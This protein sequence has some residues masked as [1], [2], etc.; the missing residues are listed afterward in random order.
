MSIPVTQQVQNSAPATMSQQSYF[1]PNVGQQNVQPHP[2]IPQRP[3]QV[4]P[5]AGGGRGGRPIYRKP[6]PEFID[7]VE[8]PRN[9]RIPEF[10]TFSGEGNQSTVKHISRFTVQCGEAGGNQW[11]KFRLFRN[12]L[13]RYA[14]RWYPNLPVNSINSWHQFKE[15][16][17]SHFYRTEPEVSMADLSRLN[18]LPGESIETFLSRFRKAK[19]KCHVDLPEV[20][21]V[22]MAVNGLD[23]ELHKKFEGVEFRDLFDLASRVAKYEGL[24]HEEKDRKAS[25]KGTYY[26]DPNYEVFAANLDSDVKVHMAELNIKKPYI[27]EA[28][29][30][31]KSVATTSAQAASISNKKGILDSTKGYSFD[32]TKAEQIFDLL[33]ADKQLIL[34]PAH[35]LPTPND[36]LGKEYCKYHNFWRHSTN[37][38]VIFRY[39]VQKA[40][41]E[42]KMKFLEKSEAMGIDGNPFR[43]IVTTNIINITADHP[44]KKVDLKEGG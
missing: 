34:T 20:E 32:I 43:V 39:I 14:F 12:T 2:T 17:H 40:I 18:Q 19:H 9:F 26:R 37:N 3:P 13:T 7:N 35:K 30:K 23:F 5:V 44:R 42:G 31:L 1:P 16:F 24:L 22:R 41:K 25:S 27:C 38:C 33:M 10:A 21:Y 28:L 6:Y 4:F 36:L 15:M 11:L 8:Y 29:V